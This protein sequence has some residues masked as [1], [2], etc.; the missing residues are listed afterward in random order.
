[1]ISPGIVCLTQ[2]IVDTDFV[3]IGKPYQQLICKRLRTG[4]NIA[5]F[6]L[7]DPDGRGDLLL[8]KVVILT[9]ILDSIVHKRSPPHAKSADTIA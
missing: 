2:K 8:R 1:M 6:S 7:R 9:E 4:F 3:I 5:I